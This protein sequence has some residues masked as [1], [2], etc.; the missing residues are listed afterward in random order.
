MLQGSG[1]ML[2]ALTFVRDVCLPLGER[3]KGEHEAVHQLKAN[4]QRVSDEHQKLEAS[5]G[6]AIGLKLGNLAGLQA[7]VSP[8]VTPEAKVGKGNS[9]NV[10]M[11]IHF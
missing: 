6:K 7:I 11:F 3:M 4:L 10:N 2:A 9:K 8:A 5:S 1:E